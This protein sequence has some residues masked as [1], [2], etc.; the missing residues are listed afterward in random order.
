MAE[1]STSSEPARTEGER[2]PTSGA[3]N[4]ATHRDPLGAL[5]NRGLDL[6]SRRKTLL[7]FDSLK[8]GVLDLAPAP[9]AAHLVQE[10]PSPGRNT[11]E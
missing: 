6:S 7:L 3:R 1:L 9:L 10:K 11:T 8:I 4:A 2:S 5:D